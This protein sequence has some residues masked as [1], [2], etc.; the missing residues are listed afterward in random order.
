M[1]IVVDDG[2]GVSDKRRKGDGRGLLLIPSL[3]G[4]NKKYPYKN[5]S[6]E[7]HIFYPGYTNTTLVLI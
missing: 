1:L 4:C 5:L 2:N 3:V 6:I 7:Q